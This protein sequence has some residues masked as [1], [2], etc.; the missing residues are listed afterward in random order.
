TFYVAKAANCGNLLSLSTAQ[1]LGLISLH[2]DKLTSK[3]AALEN[4]LQK[5]SKVFSDLGKLKGE[6]IKLDID[7][8]KIPKAQ[9]QR[10]KP[11]HIREKV[12][13]AITELENQDVI[14]K[15][16]ENEA[17]PWVSPIVAVPKKDGQVRICVDMRLAN[18]AIRRVR[19]P[20]PTVNDVNFAL[21]GAKFF[22]KLD[23]S[24]AY[25]QLELNERSRYITTFST[26]VGLYRYKR[27]N[28]GT[29]AAAEIF[30]YTLQTALQGLKRRQ[31][32][33]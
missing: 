18:E 14:E 5:H 2:L 17:T 22:S 3:D 28:Y 32:H 12:K 26:Q 8:T 25:H 19:H 13:N 27:L 33:S 29:N 16:P 20:I 1:E 31:E 23:L 30:Q 6:K 10:R 4:I 9:P 11:Y 24:Q 7:K 21:N 15:V